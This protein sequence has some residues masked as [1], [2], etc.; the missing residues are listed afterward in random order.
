MARSR[1]GRSL[2]VGG[3]SYGRRERSG[4][5]GRRLLWG[6][7]LSLVVFGGGWVLWAGTSGPTARLAEPV[8]V[9][10]TSTPL[11]IQLGAGRAGLAGYEVMAR[12]PDGSLVLLAEEEI[13]DTGLLGSGVRDRI[14]DLTLDA[15]ALGL[16]EGPSEIEVY[17]TDH[18]PTA[19]LASREPLLSVPVQ[20]DLSPP[21]IRAI[22]GQHYVAQG[23]SD[24]LVYEVGDDAVESGVTVGDLHFPG[25]HPPTLPKNVRVSLY[26]MPHDAPAGTVPRIRAVDQ[27]GN[28]REISFPVSVREKAFPAEEIRVS[29]T[30]IDGTVRPL[31]EANGKP[32]PDDP[33]EAFLAVNRVM[34]RGSERRLR[35]LTADSAP[36]LA[37]DGAFRQQPGTQVGSRFAER[38][39]YLYGDR[40]V[41]HQDHLGY[42]LASVK[43]TPILAAQAG[44]VTAAVELGIYG[45]VVLLDHGLGLSSLYAHLS[46]VDV[47]KG[48]T[49]QAGQQIGRSGETGLASGDHLHFSVLVGGHHVNPIEWWDP[50]WVRLHVEEPLAEAGRTDSLPRFDVSP[51]PDGAKGDL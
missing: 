50:K 5:L 25:H 48:D 2:Y 18:A 10:G 12:R 15:K 14:V 7:L 19:F 35:E 29:D 45:T 38:R 49:V 16:P 36:K 37:I 9:V 46:S 6:S 17:A 51:S 42:D 41:D 26:T 8:Q 39:S 40:V 34:R 13:P 4:R 43:Q 30:F 3:D 24:L 21:R 31:L 11:R 22:G 32:V 47:E 23:G 27:A 20:V 44:T 28:E 1:R 33:V